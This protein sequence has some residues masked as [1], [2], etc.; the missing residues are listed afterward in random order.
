VRTGAHGGAVAGRT[1]RDFDA[2]GQES[3]AAQEMRGLG[4]VIAMTISRAFR[5]KLASRAGERQV[6]RPSYPTER[7]QLIRWLDCSY[8]GT[9]FE[10]TRTDHDGRR[11]LDRPGAPDRARATTAQLADP[12]PQVAPKDAGRR[13]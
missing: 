7:E 10:S 8:I 3:P 9:L 12:K 5:S 1:I 4:T 13:Q 2:G 6:A 11:R